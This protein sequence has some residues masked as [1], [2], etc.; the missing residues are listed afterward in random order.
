MLSVQILWVQAE[1]S[2]PFS[3]QMRGS[4]GEA[5]PEEQVRFPLVVCTSRIH[6]IDHITLFLRAQKFSEQKAST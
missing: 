5:S 4:S 2:A 3:S 6:I 1:R